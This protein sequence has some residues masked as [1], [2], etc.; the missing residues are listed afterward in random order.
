MGKSGWSYDRGSGRWRRGGRFASPPTMGELTAWGQVDKRGRPLD[1]R[2]Q[3]VPLRSV[4]DPPKAPQYAPTELTYNPRAKRWQSPAGT[5]ASKPKSKQLPRNLDG[6]PVDARGE[7]VPLVALAD[8][9]PKAPPGKPPAPP[10]DADVLR[11]V[12]ARDQVFTGSYNSGGLNRA[13]PSGAGEA[14]EAWIAAATM[15]AGVDA[16]ELWLKNAGI[17]IHS[18]FQETL[19]ESDRAKLAELAA[20]AGV[21]IVVQQSPVG[22]VAYVKLGAETTAGAMGGAFSAAASTLSAI[23]DFLEEEWGDLYWEAYGEADED[24]Y[25]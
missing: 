6:K 1:S 2:G 22:S 23:Y 19:T 5:F 14:Y 3:G 16:D 21:T 13:D 11:V 17:A 24:W 4:V 12:G 8:Y 15:K 18:Q 25:A 10:Q 7:R 20:S 9:S